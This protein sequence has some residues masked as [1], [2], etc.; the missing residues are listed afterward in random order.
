MK[1]VSGYVDIIAMRHPQ[2]G[3][4]SEAARYTEVP[5]INAGDGKISIQLKHLQTYLL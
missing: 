1:I 3:A 5:F 4:A 2:S